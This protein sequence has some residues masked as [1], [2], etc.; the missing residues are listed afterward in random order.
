MKILKDKITA[1]IVLYNPEITSLSKNINSII[2]QVAHIYIVDN[3]S[4]NIPLIK[5]QFQSEKITWIF[6]KNNKGIATALNQLANIACSNS[7]EWLLTLDQDSLL[8]TN[9]IDLLLNENFDEKTAV[10]APNVIY[11]NNEKYSL[12]GHG[13]VEVD[14]AITSASLTNLDAWNAIGGF[15]EKLFIDGVDRDFCIRLKKAGYIIIRDYNVEITHELG[16]LH[17]INIIGKTIYV[18]NHSAIRK[19]YMARNAIYLDKKHQERNSFPYIT[20]LLLKT[21]FFETDKINKIKYINRGIRDSF[22]MMRS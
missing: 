17:C 21:I 8:P 11:K 22:K 9:Y 1:G 2:N 16:E 12:T 10:I 18:T 5:T 19:Y 15:D 13:L 20:K 14:W 4:S 6:N 7:Y 3:G